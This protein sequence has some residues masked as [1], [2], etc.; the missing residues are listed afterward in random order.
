MK[1]VFKE[2]SL[3]S[4][5]SPKPTKN[6]FILLGQL[7]IKQKNPENPELVA[8][9]SVPVECRMWS[10]FL[11]GQSLVICLCHAKFPPQ[12]QITS[13][14]FVVPWIFV[15]IIST[16]NQPACTLLCI[17]CYGFPA[18]FTHHMCERGILFV[19]HSLV[20]CTQKK[21]ND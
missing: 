13:T 10:S 7:L 18:V 17:L 15:F 3:S 21:R 20:C 9:L 2:T 4:L 5:N 8:T 12:W 11:S 1:Q 19:C 6:V 16:W 14:R